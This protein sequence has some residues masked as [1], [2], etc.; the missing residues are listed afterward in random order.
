MK[1]NPKYVCSLLA[2]FS[3]KYIVCDS[4][5]CDFLDSVNITSGVR[6]AMGNI[7][8]NNI[9][10]K[11]KYYR[12][13]DYYYEDFSQKKFVGEYIRGCPC[14][15]RLCVRMCCPHK[16]VFYGKQCVP[17]DEPLEVVVNTTLYNSQRNYELVDLAQNPMYGFLYGKPCQFVYRLDPEAVEADE[18]F[19]ARNGSIIHD[20]RLLT[21]N[22]FCFMQTNESAPVAPFVCFESQEEF[23]YALYPIGMLLSVPFL[24]ITF[25]VY[26][27]IPELRNMHGK[28][29]MCY[30]LGLAVGYTVL[31]LVQ[32]QI[33]DGDS[34]PCKVTG[35]MVYFSFMASFFWLNVMSFDIYW[36]FSGVRGAK[37]TERKK[38]ALYSL[39]AW[40]SPVLLVTLALCMDYTDLIPVAYRPMI[41]VKRC[42]LQ[43]SKLVEFLYLYLPMLLLVF[44]NVLFFVITAVRIIKIQRET[45][46]VRRGDSKRHSKLDNDRDRFSLY[47]RLFIVMGVTWSLEVISWAVE[48]NI[49]WVFYISDVC[50]CIQGFLIFMLFVWKQKVKRLI[51]KKF[52]IRLVEQEQSLSTSSTRTTASVITSSFS[53]SRSDK[54]LVTR[55]SVDRSG[56]MAPLPPQPTEWALKQLKLN[57]FG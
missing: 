41:G 6:D 9:L 12:V 56:M 13:I 23:K 55:A 3:V 34:I 16:H 42:L 25:F 47:L 33:F 19:F 31:S 27:C 29:L 30:V 22:Q 46:M 11:P 45:S 15:V 40:G 49:A 28:S 52:G 50:N 7:V 24:L 17:S 5:P 18:W 26:A 57:Q 21:R 43:S 4:L 35:Y 54:P 38:Y 14:A 10:Y 51:Y 39:Y 53:G 2:V 1:M 37:S 20:S 8:H 48:G 36:T 44:A 32:M